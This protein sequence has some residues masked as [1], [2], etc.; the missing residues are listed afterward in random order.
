MDVVRGAVSGG[1]TAVQLRDKSASARELAAAGR[2]ILEVTRPAGALFFINDRTD[3]ALA[4]G[5]D[6]VHLGPEDL[7]VSVARSIGGPTLLIG[8]STDDPVR[9]RALVEE[10][11]DYIGCGT[12]YVTT[13]KP[14]AGSAIGLSRLD[15]VARAVSVPVV[16]IGG[17]GVAGSGE[18]RAKTQAAGVAVVGAVMTADDPARVTGELLA[19]WRVDPT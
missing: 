18:V 7:P 6:G 14:D 2:Q 10:G 9:A 16:G 3:I 15:E 17:I 11:A 19:P 4:V 1:A 12:V 13:T 5:A 8:A